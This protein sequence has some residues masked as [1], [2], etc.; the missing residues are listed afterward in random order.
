M[1]EQVWIL[2]NRVNPF[3]VSADMTWDGHTFSLTLNAM[4]AE[5]FNGWVEEELGQSDMKARLQN[6]EKIPVSAVQK[7]G[8]AMSWP[9]MYIGSMFEVTPTGGRKR[10]ISIDYPSGGSISQTMSLMS[11]RKKGK[12]WKAALEG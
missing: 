11:G 7:G 3:P 5:A 10:L 12:A 9:K 1:T 2:R 8:F 6:G 4:A